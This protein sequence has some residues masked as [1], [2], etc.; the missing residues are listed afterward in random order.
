MDDVH[1]HGAHDSGAPANA[2]NELGGG[3]GIHGGDMHNMS[4]FLFDRTKGFFVLFQGAFIDST[5]GFVAGLL[6]SAAFAFI[7]TV[8]SQAIRIYEARILRAGKP[9]SKL[10]GS[11][12]HGIRQALHYFAMLLVMTMNIWVIL[13]VIVG[14]ILGW[15]FY[16]FAVH[17]FLF[18]KNQNLDNDVDACPC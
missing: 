13:A 6:L 12:M 18:R 11:I 9:L 3:G 14:H 16:T 5:G 1:G 15:L 10:L 17:R 4:P 2:T 8:L 7:A